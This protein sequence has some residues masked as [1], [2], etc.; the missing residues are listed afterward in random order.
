MKYID[1]HVHIFP[2]AIAAKAVAFLEEHYRFRWEGNGL[3]RDIEKSIRESGVEKSVV[4]SSAT[5]PEQTRHVNDFIAATV[6]DHPDQFIGFGT[7]H[8]DYPECPAEIER[9]VSLGLKG[10]KLH[11]DFQRFNLDCP[12]MMELFAL[13]EERALPVMCHVG[14]PVSECSHPRR[15]AAVLD[16]FPR[17]KFIA[18]HMG[19]YSQWDAARRYLVGRDVWF[20]T[21]SSRPFLTAEKMTELIREHGADRVLLGS[22]YPVIHQK[23]AIRFVE[24]LALTPEEKEKIFY[25]NACRLLELDLE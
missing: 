2:E 15:A 25:R 18:A 1:I 6:K 22:D 9:I 7:L 4:F 11:P 12:K 10:I 24:E 16:H 13:L 3:L 8:P 14:D 17:L 19:G 21:S 23:Q 5:K 20:D